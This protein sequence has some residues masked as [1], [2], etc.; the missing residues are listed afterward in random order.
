MFHPIVERWF[1]RR[2]QAP[3]PAQARAWRPIADGRDVLVA[4]PTGSGKTL[5]AFLACIDR[6]VRAS[7][8]G[9]LED[10]TFV[11][12]ISPLKALSNDIRKNLE[13]PLAE[14]RD[15]AREAGAAGSMDGIRAE[16]RTGDT[17][18]KDRR[19]AA[20]K[21][22]HVL[23]TTPESAF[24]LL[25]SESGRKS[26][27]K[28]RTVIVDELHAVTGDKRGAHLALSLERLDDLVMAHGGPRPQ[29]IGLSAT[30]RPIETAARLLVGSRR[31]LPEI[32]DV[33]LL[34]QL[35]LAVETPKDELGPVCTNEQWTEV[36]DRVADLAKSS[37]GILVFV[38]TRRL[39]ERV[40]LHLGTRLGEDLVAAHHGSLS[41]T[42]RLEAERKLKAGELRVVVATA[43][44]EL[45]IDIGFID[46]VCLIGSPRRVSTALQRI[47]RSGHAFGGSPKGRVFPL[48]RDQLIECGAIVRAVRKGVMDAI[49]YREAPLD[50]L[51]QQI[52]AACACEDRA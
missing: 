25:T 38:N 26:L 10:A 51:S 14:L 35:D 22:P 44:L 37:R 8:D 27:S 52:V 29:R 40:A 41:R 47:G 23:V 12:Y 46:L 17:P 48:T 2:F 34:R 21:P 45:G 6:L 20:L 31:E 5:A 32:I 11:L 28:V 3:T 15:A 13:E 7:C 18:A 4:A 39:A 30:V 24:I 42:R 16:V 1:E 33:G 49:A 36:Y 50:V 19:R 43:S 9:G